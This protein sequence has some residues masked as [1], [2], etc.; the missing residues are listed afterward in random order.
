VIFTSDSWSKVFWIASGIEIFLIGRGAG[1]GSWVFSSCWLLIGSKEPRGL[2]DFGAVL[3]GSFGSSALGCSNW[4]G[5]IF[6][7]G[8][9]FCCFCSTTGWVIIGSSCLCSTIGSTF[10]T[11]FSLIGSCFMGSSLIGSSLTGSCLMG[12]CFM[13]ISTGFSL[14]GSCFMGSSLIGSCLIGSYFMGSSLTGSLIGSCLIGSCFI[15]SILIGFSLIGSCLTGSGIISTSCCSDEISNVSNCS[16]KASSSF[17][18]ESSIFLRS[19]NWAAKSSSISF[20]SD[21]PLWPGGGGG[22]SI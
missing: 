19:S 20:V 8:S 16:R 3:G 5:I 22:S 7:F 4:R 17:S 9:G 12:S 21:E 1:V 13:G 11:G 2:K 14:I 15:G 18:I 6:G 10:S